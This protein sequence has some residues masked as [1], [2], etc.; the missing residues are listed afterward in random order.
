LELD[1]FGRSVLSELAERPPSPASALGQ[2]V[3][4]YLA[5][6]GS[7]R[8]TWSYPSFLR[9]RPRTGGATN[10]SLEIDAVTWSALRSEA[11]RQH[12]PVERLVEHALL[13]YMAG[14]DSGR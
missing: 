11:G 2:A 13:Y 10:V 6:R 1:D 5:D 3:Q 8:G 12:V 9:D 7:G 14:L 4:H